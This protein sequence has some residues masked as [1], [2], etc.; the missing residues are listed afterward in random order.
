V[1]NLRLPRG[2]QVGRLPA[3]IARA[4]A[5]PARD[6]CGYMPRRRQNSAE[7]LSVCGGRR[8]FI[9][10]PARKRFANRTAASATLCGKRRDSSASTWTI[11]PDVTPTQSGIEMVVTSMLRV[12]RRPVPATARRRR[13]FLSY[14][15]FKSGPTALARTV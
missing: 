13:L 9:A 5:Q 3:T 4:A 11:A 12:R 8:D 1:K 2:K 10:S 7:P 15:L 6:V 14:G